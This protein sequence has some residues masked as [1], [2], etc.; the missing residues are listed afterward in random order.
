MIEME[1]F[2]ELN[3]FSEDGDPPLDL[4]EDLPPPPPRSGLFSRLFRRQV[5][6]YHQ[7]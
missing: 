6:I 7:E 3:V 4:V 5:G 1:C 2:K